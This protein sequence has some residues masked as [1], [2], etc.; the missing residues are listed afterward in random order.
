MTT[1]S[2]LNTASIDTVI[3]STITDSPGGIATD[4]GQVGWNANFYFKPHGDVDVPDSPTR[5]ASGSRSS[6]ELLR[7]L[8][9]VD[10]DCPSTPEVDPR[11]AYPAL[12]L[13]GRIISA[14]FCI[15]HSLGFR[16]GQDWV[17]ISR[18]AT[19]LSY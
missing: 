13:S 7:R 6:A 14:T 2:P 17:R 3:G 1:V 4:S 12:N 8:S 19:Q 5:A 10:S 15:P 11:A 9:L 16:S 18:M